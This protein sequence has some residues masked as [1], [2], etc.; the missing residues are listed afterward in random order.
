MMGGSDIDRSATEDM[1]RSAKAQE[2]RVA[3]LE[4]D[5]QT[6]RLFISTVASD[7]KW[8]DRAQSILGVIG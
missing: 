3:E 4:A 7:E 1:T 6:A 2:A 8:K 5:L